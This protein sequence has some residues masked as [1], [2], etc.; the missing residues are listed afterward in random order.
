M[1]LGGRVFTRPVAFASTIIICSVFSRRKCEFISLYTGQYWVPL[2][3][4]RWSAVWW[5]PVASLYCHLHRVDTA[6]RHDSPQQQHILLQHDVCAGNSV[7]IGVER[8][9][10]AVAKASLGI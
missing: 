3:T 9:G 8:T 2:H 10:H 1:F 6:S 4:Y 7:S 5:T